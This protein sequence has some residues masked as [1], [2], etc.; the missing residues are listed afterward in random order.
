MHIKK[1]YKT[2]LFIKNVLF[3]YSESA[4]QKKSER[5][6]KSKCVSNIEI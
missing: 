4:K 5:K 6:Q 1:I 2:L 3:K